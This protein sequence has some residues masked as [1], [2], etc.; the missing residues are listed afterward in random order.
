MWTI[1]KFNLSSKWIAFSGFL[2]PKCTYT[3]VTTRN[4]PM[5]RE[6]K[7]IARARANNKTMKTSYKLGETSNYKNNVENIK[8]SSKHLESTCIGNVYIIRLSKGPSL[9]SINNLFH[10]HACPPS[11]RIRTRNFLT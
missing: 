11:S 9:L 7:E 3:L 1:E 10:E 4:I 8:A 6:S 2:Q 5:R